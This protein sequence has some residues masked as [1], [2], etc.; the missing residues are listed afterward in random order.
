MVSESDIHSQPAED[1]EGE[2]THDKNT[3]GESITKGM[4]SRIAV[5]PLFDV[6]STQMT[7]RLIFSDPD[8]KLFHGEQSLDNTLWIAAAITQAISHALENMHEHLSTT[9]F[10]ECIGSE[11]IKILEDLESSTQKVRELTSAAGEPGGG[12]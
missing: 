9:A 2:G 8:T 7:L 11:F 3:S 4:I 6:N 10:Q 5:A 1:N 12:V